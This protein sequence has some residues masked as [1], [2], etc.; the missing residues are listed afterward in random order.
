MKKIFSLLLGS[1]LLLSVT[2]T[3]C[4]G[5]ANLEFTSSFSP[6]K[7]QVGYK[8]V[9]TYDVNYVNDS[10]KYPSLA[11]TF[12]VDEYLEKDGINYSGTLTTTFEVKSNVN[13]PNGDSDV[14]AID[15]VSEIY[16]YKSELNLTASYNF[17]GGDEMDKTVN[18]NIVS[19]T[20]F[21]PAEH[22]FAPIYSTYHAEM[23]LISLGLENPYTKAV[24]D[25]V[26]TYTKSNYN[27]DKKIVMTAT[28][29]DGEEIKQETLENKTL[30]YSF[31]TAIDNNALNFAIRNYKTNEEQSTR[32]SVISP[33]YESATSLLISKHTPENLAIKYPT[34]TSEEQTVPVKKFSMS[35]ENTNESGLPH[36]FVVQN[37]ASANGVVKN[38]ALLVKYAAP[39]FSYN[40]MTCMGAIEYSLSSVTIS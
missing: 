31:K 33:A 18:D 19:E 17:K 30:G 32:I 6:D 3:G 35:V 1:A 24:Y 7:T 8:E 39:L 11:R 16:Y 4:G 21:L 40:I 25:F 34:N 28:N 2:L 38:N 20:Y 23:T 13:V 29:S 9:L 37:G 27:L 12:A 15:G 22:S 10:S 5:P 26:T 14:M 36:Y